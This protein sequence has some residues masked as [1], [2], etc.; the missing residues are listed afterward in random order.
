MNDSPTLAILDQISEGVLLVNPSG[1]IAFHNTASAQIFDNE[2]V[3]DTFFGFSLKEDKPPE[4]FLFTFKDKELSIRTRFLDR[5]LLL[6]IQDVT[7]E[8]K[9]E[10]LAA[11]HDR[12]KELGDIVAKVAHEIRNPLGGIRGFASLLHRD[13]KAQ[14]E[15]QEMAQHIIEGSDHLSRF[16]TS[17]LNYSRP[18]QVH[19]QP[20]D[21][22]LLVEELIVHV[23]ADSTLDARIALTSH[24]A[25]TPLLAHVDAP[26]LQS[27]LLNLVVNAIQAM[28]EGGS[29]S[30]AINQQ[31]DLAILQ[32]SDTGIGIPLKIFLNSFLPF[33]RLARAAMA[34]V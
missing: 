19:L 31:E 28:P 26:L 2:H 17:V 29:L 3:T 6:I 33:S 10:T 24:L 15:L 16:V 32:V 5:N 4:K 34:L 7:E 8:K 21:L 30:I 20:C 11:R 22:N 13:L 18:T 9:L 23:K 1:E 25:P 12:M 27:A 14:P